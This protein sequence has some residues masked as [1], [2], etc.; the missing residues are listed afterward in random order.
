MADRDRPPAAALLYGIDA[1]PL[2]AECKR[3]GR[4]GIGTYTRSLLRCLL[5]AEK[6]PTE[7][8]ALLGLADE[9][10]ACGRLSAGSR[11]LVAGS[12]LNGFFADHWRTP[13]ALAGAGAQVAWYPSQLQAPL[14]QPV[15]TVITVHDVIPQK[16]P[17]LYPTDAREQVRQR[18]MEIACGRAAALIAVSAATKRDLMDIWC[19]PAERITVIHEA[20]QPA[21][22]LPVGEAARAELRGRHNLPDRFFLY[23]GGMDPR[24]T[25]AIALQGAG[26]LPVS[27]RLPWVVLA[28][29]R[30]AELEAKVMQ[31]ARAANVAVQMVGP[32]AAAD[33][34]VMC[35][36]AA[37]L[38][39]PTRDEGC[40]L[41]VLDALAAGLPVVASAAGAIP[42][43]AGEAFVAVREET[44]AAWAAALTAVREPERQEHLRAAGPRQVADLTWEKAA[45]DTLAVL[46]RAAAGAQG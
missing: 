27:R 7:R 28:G 13:R 14:H 6:M 46:R 34:P 30:D 35:A 26:L 16:Y 44:P 42:E 12:R 22:R 40:S 11:L 33:L 1:R 39:M 19:I 5:A 9:I 2:S 32:V 8:L 37:A 36:L 45:A 23:I 18:A 31:A 38:V 25:L 10:T 21:F 41:P 43:M 17:D 20:P 29:N 4:G 15:P 24:K 3:Q